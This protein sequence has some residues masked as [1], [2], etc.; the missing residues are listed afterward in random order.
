MAEPGFWDD[1]QEGRGALGRA[2]PPERRVERYDSLTGEVE[3]LEEL[4][5]LADD[6]ELVELEA[7]V[8]PLKRQL[9]RL[10]ED[11]LFRGSTT[12]ATPS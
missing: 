7:A 2:R 11:A 9:E 3:D 12:P 6:G 10:E 5:E 1:Q 4:V 8:T